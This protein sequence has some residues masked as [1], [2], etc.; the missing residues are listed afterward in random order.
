MISPGRAPLSLFV[1]LIAIGCSSS[2]PAEPDPQ[3]E[4]GSIM[5]TVA[6]TGVSLDA[7]GYSVTLGSTTQAVDVNGST[8]LTDVAAGSQSVMLGD[9]ATNCTVTESNPQSVTV[10]NNQTATLTFGV[11]CARLMEAVTLMATDRNG[12]FYVVDET[13]GDATALFAP[14]ADSAATM[15]G[16]GVVSSMV[17]VWSTDTWWLGLGGQ[18]AC[19][20]CLHTLD[21]EAGVSTFLSDPSSTIRAL[22]GMTVHPTTGRIYTTE[23]DS[24]GDLYELDSVTGAISVALVGINDP[25]SGKGMTFSNDGLLYI[26]GG[27]RLITVDIDGAGTVDLG[28]PV[29][30]GFPVA[31]TSSTIR[32]MATRESDGTVFVITRDGRTDPAEVATMNLTTGELTHLGTNIELLDGLAF[33]PTR[34]L[35]G[36]AAPAAPSRE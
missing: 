4:I 34:L 8:T 13:T 27:N 14:T 33:I 9:V 15:L 23:G 10:V 28:A 29:L 6:T 21:A 7:D 36:A 25:G 26:G 2:T 1:L 24:G 3:P 20:G 35:V 12:V 16:L 11:V 17:H 5:V 30:T 22:A 19:F 18:S 31:V 32:S